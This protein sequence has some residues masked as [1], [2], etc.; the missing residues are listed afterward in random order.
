MEGEVVEEK[1]KSRPMGTALVLLGSF[2]A[3]A[4]TRSFL[5]FVSIRSRKEGIH[6]STSITT[7]LF[8]SSS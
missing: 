7:N 3:E 2:Y 1:D 4:S 5:C 6:I 8:S